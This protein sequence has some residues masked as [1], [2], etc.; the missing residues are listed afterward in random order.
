MKKQV[1]TSFALIAFAASL[2]FA[3]PARADQHMDGYC[4]MKTMKHSKELGLSKKQEAKIKEIKDK[5]WEQLKPIAEKASGEVESVLNEKQKAKYKEL[6]SSHKDCGMG[7]C[8]CA[9]CKK[10]KGGDCKECGSCGKE[11]AGGESCEMKEKK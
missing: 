4:P 5:M 1:L 11:K 9:E 10:G 3:L 7:D 2:A 6:M 8:E